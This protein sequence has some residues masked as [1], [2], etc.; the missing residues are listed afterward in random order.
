LKNKEMKKVILLLTTLFVFSCSSIKRELIPTNNK[1]G[2][3]LTQSENNSEN[4]QKEVLIYGKIVDIK[5]NEPLSKTQILIG[6]IKAEASISGEYSVKIIK[7]DIKQYIEVSTVG[8]KKIKTNFLKLK[9]ETNLK[10]DFFIE[11]D[12]SLLIDCIG[13]IN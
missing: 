11:E 9:D 2:Y 1:G 8:Y 12:D 13:V 10:I 7:S 4:N 6:C 3:I 5:T